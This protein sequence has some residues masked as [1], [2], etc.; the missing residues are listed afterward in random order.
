[1]NQDELLDATTRRYLESGDFNGLPLHGAEPENGELR[2]A[3]RELVQSGKLSINFGDRHPNPHVLAFEA[4]SVNEQLAKIDARNLAGACVYPTPAHLEKVVDRT[5]YDRRPYTLELALGAPQLGFHYFDLTVLEMYRND[6]RYYYQFDISGFIGV[7]DEYFESQAMPERDQVLLQSFGL[8][9]ARQKHWAV[10][11]FSRY[12]HQLSPEHQ[13]YWKLKQEPDPENFWPHPDYWR[14]SMGHWPEKLSL[15]SAF[16][17]ELEQINTLADL[18]GRPPLFRSTFKERERPKTFGYLMRPTAKELAEFAST[19]DKMISDNINRDFFLDDVP[20]EEEIVD[21]RGRHIVQQ[22]GT[23]RILDEWTRIYFTTDD[24]SL[25]DYMIATF[26]K[27][28]AARNPTAHRLDADRYD[29]ALFDEQIG[30][31]RDTYR[32]ILTLRQM[33]QNHPATAGYELPELLHDGK[34]WAS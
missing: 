31:M 9:L 20:F 10:I 8:A 22:K 6:P 4:E 2:A 30:L 33:L 7:T 5:A 17:S 25:L 23:I 15:F 12:L 19:L 14:S 18:I 11:A 3:L 34:V 26:K 27:V 1:M 32:A 28:R 24:R 16:L 21:K 29:M 13:Q